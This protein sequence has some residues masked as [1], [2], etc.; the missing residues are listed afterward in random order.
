MR[1]GDHQAT[2][3]LPSSPTKRWK[4]AVLGPCNK[5][6]DNISLKVPKLRFSS[7]Y[8]NITFGSQNALTAMPFGLGVVVQKFSW[9][10]LFS[11]RS[12]T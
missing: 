10:I 7:L 2:G 12:G 8:V 3:M 9:A 11:V 4:T 5:F 6:W 1:T